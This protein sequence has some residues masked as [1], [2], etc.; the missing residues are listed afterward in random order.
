MQKKS[1]GFARNA[2]VQCGYRDELP[3]YAR[4]PSLRLKNGYGQDYT[5]EPTT[6]SQLSHLKPRLFGV[7]D[8]GNR[9]AHEPRFVVIGADQI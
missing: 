1:P 7:R 9:H 2:A 8:A 3:A 6:S 5:R 4:D